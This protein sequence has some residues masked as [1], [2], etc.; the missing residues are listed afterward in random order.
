MA[1]VMKL[2]SQ[3]AEAIGAPAPPVRSSL[4]SLLEEAVLDEARYPVGTVRKWRIGGKDVDMVKTG[5]GEWERAEKIKK[6]EK[7]DAA[8]AVE[9]LGNFLSK[10]EVEVGGSTKKLHPDLTNRSM[11]DHMRI[12]EETRAA[13]VKTLDE[14]MDALREMF[15][16]AHVYGRVKTA[17][18]AIGK[19]VRKPKLLGE[20]FGALAEGYAT[21]ADLGDMGAMRAVFKTYAELEAAVKKFRAKY[22][23]CGGDTKDNCIVEEDDYLGDSNP[24]NRNYPYRS[25]HLNMR[26]NGLVQEIQLRT[27]DMDRFGDWY[28]DV[29]KPR[30]PEQKAFYQAHKA[31]IE[32]YAKAISDWFKY[33]K[34]SKPKCPQSVRESFGCL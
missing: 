7:K 34:G 3:L 21:A 4:S 1:E 9:R 24:P 27:V 32:A 8:D 22:P 18:S 26:R 16:E 11:D 23:P 30:R 33:R 14:N 29:Y 17:H 2:S 20:S 28:H 12:A 5:H 19:L 31:E 6:T 15:P 25:Y 13:H 10:G